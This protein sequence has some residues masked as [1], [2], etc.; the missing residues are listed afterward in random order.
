MKSLLDRDALV[1]NPPELGCVL[2]L[3][4]LPGGGNKIYDQSPYGN[5]ATITGAV[6]KR[7]PSG[8]WCLSFDGTDDYVDC[9]TDASLAITGSFSIEVWFKAPAYVAYAHLASK[10]DGSGGFRFQT[11]YGYLCFRTFVG[12]TDYTI[13]GSSH[14]CDGVWHQTVGVFN[15]DESK[16]YLYVDGVLDTDLAGA[17]YAPAAQ[18]MKLRVG[19]GSIDSYQVWSSLIGEVRI[20]NR[21]LNALEIQN[22]FN[23]EKHLFGVW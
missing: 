1:F 2:F 23:Q 13:E 17:N 9:G 10:V 7:L 8:L 14:F 18:T 6:W 12:A 11:A 16:N 22:H 5:I 19:C 15:A 4:G 21:A 20:Y 3:P